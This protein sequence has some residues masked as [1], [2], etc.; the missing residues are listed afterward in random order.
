VTIK[1]R[2]ASRF[3]IAAR[4]VVCAAIVSGAGVLGFCQSATA[5]FAFEEE[6]LPPR[7]V[8]WRLADRGFTGLSRPRFDGRV[9]VVD[10]VSPT[11]VPVRLFV[12]PGMGAIVGRQRLG[13]PETYARLERPA[14]GFGWTEEDAG[15]RGAARPLSPEDNPASRP[16]RRPAGEA[17]R[18]ELDPDGVNPDNVGRSTPPRK[19]ARA[20]PARPPE[21]PAHRV[22][23][24]APA[25][26]LAPAEAAKAEPG[27]DAKPET[28]SAAIDKAPPA[29]P[30]PAA[31]AKTSESTLAA[32][33]KPP[34]QDWK[35][36]PADKKPVRV[37]GGATI[38]PG[39]AEK[40]QGAAQ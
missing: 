26:K 38:V 35:D 40:E 22:S 21:K 27:I 9:Y 20:N 36:P 32:A 2:T 8:A 3:R 6:V 10:A 25:P 34:A 15:A 4:S 14:P 30:A 18:P 1:L 37:I 28:K 39:T 31:A 7:V 24:E 17:L 29:T 23:P 16:L 11:G 13:A 19:V 12:D 33:S 5:Q